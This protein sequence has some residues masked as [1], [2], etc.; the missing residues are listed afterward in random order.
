MKDETLRVAD[1]PPG[2]S[3]VFADDG[4]DMDLPQHEKGAGAASRNVSGAGALGAAP[5]ASQPGSAHGK[6]SHPAGA[7]GKSPCPRAS[8]GS[9]P[10]LQKAAVFILSLDEEAA[11]LVLRELADDDL[12][13]IA[14]EIAELGL[15]E[16]ET[17]AAVILEFA[18]LERLHSLV[19]EGGMDQAVRIVERSFPK[20]KARRILQLLAAQRQS[21]PFAFLEKVELDT[22]MAVIEEEHPQTL[23]VILA[24]MSPARAA[25]V[26]GRL[27]PEARRE[28]L[29]RI[30]ALD[31]ANAEALEQ[32]ELVLEKCLDHVRYESLGDA[33]G[34][35]AVAQILRAAAREGGAF[36]DDIRQEQP[37]LADEIGKHLFAFEDVARLD[38]RSL[39][40]VLRG[41]DTKLLALALAEAGDALKRKFLDNLGRRGAEDLRLEMVRLGPVRRAD[42]E[43]A[44]DAIIQAVLASEGPS[45]ASCA[46]RGGEEGRMSLS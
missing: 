18:E 5:G 13:R 15:V 32:V 10:G 30:A 39:Q 43:A 34:I 2:P 21:L 38:D 17:V 28:V 45:R 6:A 29:E 42:I 33:G 19:R 36:L 27:G 14:A 44:Q 3:A 8:Q 24:H 25:E 37:E 31:G 20:E 7:Q 23:A 46:L 26:L 35:R 41:L 9:L 22:L 40:G 1:P 12:S 16:K 4:D 11:S